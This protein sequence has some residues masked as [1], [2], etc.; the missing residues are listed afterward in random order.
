M[1]EF[2]F[3]FLFFYFFFLY[4]TRLLH[5]WDFPG[6]NTGVGC[7]F[8]LQKNFLSCYSRVIPHRMYRYTTFCLSSHQLSVDFWAA[9]TC[10][11]EHGCTNKY[12]K[13]LLLIYLN[14]LYPEMELL[15]NMV[16]LYLIFFQKLPTFHRG[17]TIL[18]PHKQYT[19]IPT[20][21][22][23][24]QYFVLFLI[25]A[26]LIDMKWYLIIFLICICL[27]ESTGLPRWH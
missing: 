22:R 13:T 5:P 15:D 24:C 20:S 1:L 23:P 14:K 7:H 10:H 6:K 2:S 25:A 8:L 19:R 18:H 4:P 11:Q 17:C 27:I 9:S 16:I 3:F 26:I 12:I 21:P